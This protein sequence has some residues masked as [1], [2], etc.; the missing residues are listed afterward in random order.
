[1]RELLLVCAASAPLWSGCKASIDERPDWDAAERSVQASTGDAELARPDRPAQPEAEVDELLADGLQLEDAM[2]L[3]LRRS[4]R[5]VAGF[6]AI[7]VAQADYARAGLLENPVLGL[8]LLAPDGGGRAKLAADLAQPLTAIWR[9]PARRAEARAGVEL[10]MAELSL[11]AR[12]LLVETRRA[13]TAVALSRA[14]MELSAA[15]A[16]LARRGLAAAEALAA[17]GVADPLQVATARTTLAAAELRLR[18]VRA[19]SDE[20]A[21]Q[22]AL[23]LR[24]DRHLDAVDVR[25]PSSAAMDGVEAGTLVA[26]ACE[27]RADLLVSAAGV[28]QAEAAL[29]TAQGEAMPEV[30]AGIGFERPETEGA[31]V[32]GPEASIELPLFHRNQAAIAAARQELLRR[33]ALHAGLLADARREVHSALARESAA[34][35]AAQQA[36]DLLVP[37][38]VRSLELL[39]KAVALGDATTLDA[40]AARRALLEAREAEHE[41]RAEAWRARLALEE[42]VGGPI[43]VR[44]AAVKDA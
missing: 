27:R 43:P 36:S 15:D 18:G 42:A 4:P 12:E 10:A 13:W 33:Q 44:A 37:E 14:A 5:L 30:S 1:M 9:L 8:S 31:P 2:R 22:L 21:R 38:A 26:I 24:L 35:A 11:V 7:G 39:D 6:H 19:S 34:R 25:L 23:L 32:L 20:D 3:A 16:E 40:L 28:A 17:A 29:R 41:A